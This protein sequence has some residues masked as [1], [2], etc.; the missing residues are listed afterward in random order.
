MPN[1]DTHTWLRLIRIAGLGSRS[2]CKLASHFSDMNETFSASDTQLQKSGLK[3]K[4]ISALR[5]APAQPLAS[6]L[7]WLAQP[8]NHLITLNHPYY[9]PL[10]KQ[11]S[12]PPAALFAHGDI[13]L[14]QM[15][16]L[17]IVGAR[18]PTPAGRQTGKDFA[19]FLSQAGLVITSGMAWGIDAAAHQGALQASGK[20]IA[21]VGTGLDRVYPADHRQLAHDISQAGLIISEFPLGVSA[22]PGHFPKRNRIIAGLAAGT[23]VVEAA[24]KSGSLITAR[25]AAEEGRSV[26]ALPGSIHNPLSRGCHLLIKQ[27]AQLVETA[28]DI[29]Q[30]MAV[31]LGFQADNFT[32]EKSSQQ[33]DNSNTEMD[34]DYEQLLDAMG[35]DPVSADQLIQRCQFPAGEVSSM[36]LLLEL[37]GHVSSVVGGLYQRVKKPG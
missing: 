26:F 23:L 7:D 2:L 9:P 10:L 6:D 19:R 3:V 12:D 25:L 35:Y 8:C 11:S 13:S 36:L 20:T 34:A 30:D 32:Q 37:D 28:E 1:A 31:L 24:I 4:Q 5:S 27:G 21:V 17:A 29:I 16:Q 15:P 14:L 22:K 18:N 33:A